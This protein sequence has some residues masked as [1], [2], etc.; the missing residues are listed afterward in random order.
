MKAK[1][2]IMLGLIFIAIT[3][4]LV[5]VSVGWYSAYGGDVTLSGTSVSITTSENNYYGGSADLNY[6]GCLTK[7]KDNYSK[8]EYT[9]YYGE[10][11]INDLYILLLSSDTPIYCN[12][13][14]GYV[15]SCSLTVPES[16]TFQ[17]SQ[18]DS[19]FTVVLL[20]KVDDD[21]YKV[22]SPTA[23]SY[24]YFAIIFGNMSDEFPYSARDYIGT[25]FALNI[26]LENE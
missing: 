10:D 16:Q 24:Q 1:L 14:I 7:D 12:T 25:G 4:S 13:G 15:D 5:A 8:V 19:P 20:D 11:G 26:K 21:N 9:P 18:E 3:I 6:L 23:E 2:Q 17:F 22:A